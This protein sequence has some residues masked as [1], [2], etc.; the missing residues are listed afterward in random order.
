MR[1]YLIAFNLT[2]LVFNYK[3][4]F[5][6]SVGDFFDFIS[7]NIMMPIV[8]LLTCVLIGYI[9]KPKYIE[10]ETVVTLLKW[11]G[12]QKPALPLHGEQRN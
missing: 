12:A 4:A 10:E 8:A 2:I 9:V 7:N 5:S 3:V 6:L 11:E 1:I